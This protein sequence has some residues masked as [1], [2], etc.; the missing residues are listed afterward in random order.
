MNQGIH[1]QKALLERMHKNDVSYDYYQLVCLIALMII[2][3]CLVILNALSACRQSP[4]N[5]IRN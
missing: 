1:E 4:V 5:V 2:M 3:I